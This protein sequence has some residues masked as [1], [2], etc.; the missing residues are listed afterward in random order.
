MWSEGGRTDAAGFDE[1]AVRLLRCRDALQA[2]VEAQLGGP[3]K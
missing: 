3:G 1:I 2:L